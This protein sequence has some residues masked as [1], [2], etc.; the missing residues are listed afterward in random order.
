VH[1]QQTGL[2]SGT[3][4]LARDLY[5]R[6]LEDDPRYAPA[7]ARLGRC[8]RVI[9]KS[10]E[11]PEENSRR[12]ES[13][14][15]RA[16]ELNSSLS[17]AHKLYAQLETDVGRAVDAMTRLLSRTHPG[18]AD[19]E[20]FAGLVQ[21]C[22]YC[23]LLEASRAAHEHARRL[24]PRIPTGVRHTLWLLH[25]PARALEEAGTPWFYFEGVVLTTMGREAE[26]LS[27][28]RERERED[29][30]EAMRVFIASLRALLEGKRE[31]SLEATERCLAHFRDPEV[32][33]YLARQLAHLGAHERA[34]DEVGRAIDGGF[35]CPRMLERDPWLDPL[36]STPEFGAI[37]ERAQDGRRQAAAA[38]VEAGGDRL[39]GVR[40]E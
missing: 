3:F 31:E 7:W 23:G 16:L 35:S 15:Q 27:V 9:G 1:V 38:F 20:L 21:A 25:E 40:P 11:D 12:A 8:Y 24:D 10:G 37:L 22:R 5:L 39:L 6:C 26:A 33:Y 13:S 28:L 34:L 36:R 19:P 4:T 18:S 2:A 14:F 17:L 30:P 29:R 32:R